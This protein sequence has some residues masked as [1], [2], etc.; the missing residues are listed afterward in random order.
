MSLGQRAAVTDPGRRRR[1]NE[2]AYVL[3]PPL[4]AVADGMG[5]A[6]AGEIASRIAASVLRD[7]PAGSGQQAV[8]TL[9]QEANRRVYEAA[10]TDE[11]RSG[12]GTTITAAVVDDGAV[13]LGHVGDS[14]AYRIRDGRLEQ[15]TEDHSLVAELVRSGRLSPEEAD[16]HPQRSVI[17]RALGTDPDVDVDTFTVETRPGDV[18]MICSDGLTSMVDDRAILKLV[19]QHRSDLEQ[20]A[21]ALVKAANDGGGEDNITVVV[22][23]I[24]DAAVE[25][26]APSPAA[27]EPE[28]DE[29][30]T[31]SGL[32]PVPTIDDTMLVSRDELE[33]A[34][35]EP[36]H[37]HRRLSRTAVLAGSGAVVVVLAALLVW[38][39]SR[40]Y[41]V[42]A[43][44]NG[45]LAVYQGF[46]W[47]IAGGIKLYRVRYQSPV[48]AGELSQTERR[49]LFDHDLRSYGSALNAVRRFEAEVVP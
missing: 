18:F 24:V 28:A 4:F 14:R 44:P 45:H 23:E 10:A 46:P 2:D 3:E 1:R 6:Q 21:R 31:L 39:L 22:F 30:T 49:R 43:Q 37:D 20:A 41:F 8:V 38:T 27:A 32:E 42:G 19:E 11:A 17:T 7:S 12:M 13:H 29:E 5:G 48:L 33:A 47:N 26:T 36:P 16:V 34:P 40:S 9:I 25:Q 15:L 35:A